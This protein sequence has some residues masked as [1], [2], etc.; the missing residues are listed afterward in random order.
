M[1]RSESNQFIKVLL[2]LLTQCST[3]PSFHRSKS[4]A[5]VVPRELPL[6]LDKPP[7]A[8]HGLH[9]A[10]CCLNLLSGP[11]AAAVYLH[12]K[13]PSYI[14]TA[15]QLDAIPFPFH[16]PT[17]PEKR[18][19]HHTVRSKS[20]QVPDV[21]GRIHFSERIIKTSLGNTALQRHLPTLEPGA[22][23]SSRTRS[24]TFGASTRGFTTTRPSSAPNSSGFLLCSPRWL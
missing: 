5:Q 18:F 8:S 11:G 12:R 14:P 9:L 17:L 20:F 3:V 2:P 23:A 22:H 6:A 1:G 13:R 19:I 21:D 10:S 7:E 15:Q 16:Q 4:A 24:L